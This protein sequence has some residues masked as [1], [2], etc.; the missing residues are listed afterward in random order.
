[1][2]ALHGNAPIDVG[3]AIAGLGPE[4]RA[5]QDL[6]ANRDPGAV[7][8]LIK[9]QPASLRSAIHDFDPAAHNLARLRA[10]LVLVHGRA[11]D[12]IPFTESVALA[13]SVRPGQAEVFITNGLAHVELVPAAGDVPVLARAIGAVL[14]F[15]DR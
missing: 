4:G 3:Q 6:L 14:A 1:M 12:V 15:R 9:G 2:R 10:R 5:L 8:E 7:R 13:R 11:D